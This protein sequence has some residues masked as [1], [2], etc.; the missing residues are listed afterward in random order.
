MEIEYVKEH[1]D[2]YDVIVHNDTHSAC[3]DLLADK[4]ITIKS[5]SKGIMT[6]GI[7][8]LIPEGYYAEIRNK[9]RIGFKNDI[10]IYSG[11]MDAGYSGDWSVKAFNYGEK[12][13]VVKK[14]D[15]IAQVLIL[16]KSNVVM[17]EVSDSRF[18]EYEESSA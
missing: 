10:Y 8:I 2:A 14:G 3:V 4:D 5:K 13:F 18:K 16:K 6:C 17:K 12:D 7:R 9:S 11:I 15:S 1:K